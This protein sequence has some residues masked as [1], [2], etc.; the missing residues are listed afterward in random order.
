M[1]SSGQGG[2]APLPTAARL[3]L[4]TYFVT[5]WG[6]GFVVTRVALEYAA[7]APVPIK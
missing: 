6:T 1:S 5:I 2:A 7:L 3:L 4:S